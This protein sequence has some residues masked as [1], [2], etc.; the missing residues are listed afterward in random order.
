MPSLAPTNSRDL[1]L[2][3]F[4][5][6]PSLQRLPTKIK[7]FIPHFTT[8]MQKFLVPG[9]PFLRFAAIQSLIFRPSQS[10]LTLYLRQSI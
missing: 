6:T 1:T 8:Q 2:R 5:V 7:E 3:V 9:F 10:S 4:I